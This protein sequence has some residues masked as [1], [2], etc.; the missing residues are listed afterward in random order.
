MCDTCLGVL[1][2]Q[3]KVSD[4]FKPELQTIMDT[5]NQTGVLWKNTKYS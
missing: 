1:S 3:I 5:R 4:P 2:S